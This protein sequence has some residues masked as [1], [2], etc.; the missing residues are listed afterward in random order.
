MATFG[1]FTVGQVLTAAELNAA[2]AYTAY[3]P[4]YNGFTLGNG[5]VT[6]RYTQ[7]NKV[8]HCLGLV[9]LGTTS[10]LAG[11]LDIGL[12]VA[13]D[14]TV[15]PILAPFAGNCLAYNGSLL[16]DAY[17]IQVSSVF[18]RMVGR[19]VNGTYSQNYDMSTNVPFTWNSSA[20]FFWSFIYK[21]A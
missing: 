3:T 4:A 6:A 17:P 19:L 9:D 21:A 1:T 7:F 8:V 12:P 5:I 14:T 16:F 11:P 13:C 18:F 2:G 15:Q 20:Y 10:S